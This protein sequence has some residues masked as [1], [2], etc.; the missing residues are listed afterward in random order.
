MSHYSA[1]EI[2]SEYIKLLQLTPVSGSMYSDRVILDALYALMA[3]FFNKVYRESNMLVSRY[4]P[5][6]MWM[7]MFQFVVQKHRIDDLNSASPTLIAAL[8]SLKNS[9]KNLK[10]E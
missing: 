4:E 1:N 7:A 6:V 10:E 3:Y 2:R 9:L 8:E 5:I